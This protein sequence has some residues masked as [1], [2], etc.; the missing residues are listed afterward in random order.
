LDRLFPN[1]D[2]Q[3]V[4]Q[5]IVETLEATDRAWTAE[6]LRRAAEVSSVVT[7]LVVLARLT[8]AGVIEHP[9]LGLYCRR[10]GVA[11]RSA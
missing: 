11:R 10:Q 2:D 4:A 3:A 1:V 9:G 5:R 7:L 8:V 6:E